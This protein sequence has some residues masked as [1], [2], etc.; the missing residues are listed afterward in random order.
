[1][2]LLDGPDCDM[3][4]SRLP[5]HQW[6]F[7]HWK[8]GW[9][10]RH[11]RHTWARSHV[12]VHFSWGLLNAKQICLPSGVALC[13]LPLPLSLFF[14]LPLLTFLLEPLPLPK[15]LLELEAP[16]PQEPEA[17]CRAC[18]SGACR[19][20]VRGG[21]ELIGSDLGRGCRCRPSPRP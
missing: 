14:P 3:P 8:A 1:M 18:R 5:D 10:P 13:P 11:V 7:V 4:P 9:P 15:P 21:V 17:P 16:E 20:D 2:A 12:P 6:S 19:P